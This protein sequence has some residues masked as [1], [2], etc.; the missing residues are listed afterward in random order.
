MF[1][2]LSSLKALDLGVNRITQLQDGVFDGLH[3]LEKL[4]LIRNNISTVGLRVFGGSAMLGSLKHV[5]LQQ[6]NIQTLEPWPLYMGTNHTVKINLNFNNISAFTNTM[7]RKENCGMKTVIRFN[8]LLYGN[9]LGHVSD[10]LSG[11]NMSLSTTWCF[12]REYDRHYISL[13]LPV[14]YL[15]CDCG[16]FVIFSLLLPLHS[17]N[18]SEVIC[19]RL[20]TQ[21]EDNTIPWEQLVCSLNEGCP[22][23]CRC[24]HQAANA[25]LHVNCSNANLTDFPLE[26]PMPKSYP[27]Y[28]LHFSNNRFLR[29][30]EHRDYLV[31]TSILDISNSSIQPTDSIDVWR[32]ILQIPEVNFYR[33]QLTS[34]PKSVVSLNITT[35]SLNISDNPWS[36]SCDNMWMSSWLHSIA[37]WL[38]DP[39]VPCYTP[40]RL[41]DKPIIR[42]SEM[43]FCVDLVAVAA[44]EASRRAWKISLL[45]VT[46]VVVVLLSVIAICRSLR[47]KLYTRWKFHPFDRDECPGEDMDYDVF[48]CCSSL[49]DQ[50]SGGRILDSMEASGYRVCYHERDFMPGLIVDNISA[51]VTRSKRTIC[52]LTSNFIQRFA[53]VSFFNVF[54]LLLFCIF[55]SPAGSF[56]TVNRRQLASSIWLMLWSL[57]YS[58]ST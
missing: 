21:R 22:F 53:N 14:I 19:N 13:G 36:C 47:L 31:N 3:K 11:W 51:S 55:Y 40:L 5:S 37:D 16:N 41:R 38:T 18:L 57:Q 1:S 46:G 7:R 49:D 39:N 48:L 26:L 27:K 6:N 2:E 56:V 28:V 29:R 12:R 20:I 45:P 24:I 42:T 30:L 43:D 15:D 35:R 23:G 25:T 10:L 17:G 33:N 9:P 8:L 52:L 54:C 50:T 32:S 34:I 4:D 44:A 58:T